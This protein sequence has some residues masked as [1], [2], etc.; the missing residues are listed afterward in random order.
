MVYI[1]WLNLK[2]LKT[3]IKPLINYYD[4]TATVTYCFVS[5]TVYMRQDKLESLLANPPT[6]NFAN[7]PEEDF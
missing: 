6:C 1:D 7:A 4:H 3:N 5:Y 2:D